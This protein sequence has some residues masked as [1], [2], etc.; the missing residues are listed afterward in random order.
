[1]PKLVAERKIVS[2]T[3]MTALLYLYGTGRPS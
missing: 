2:G 3:S 1:V